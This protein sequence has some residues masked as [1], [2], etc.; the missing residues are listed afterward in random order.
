MCFP[1]SQ[2]QGG[3]DYKFDSRP[4]KTG[5]LESEISEKLSRGITNFIFGSTEAVRTPVEWGESIETGAFKT[6]TLGIPFGILRAGARTLVGLY[7]IVTC[8]APQKPIMYPL[9]GD[10][11]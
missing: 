8:Y 4:V 11:V 7:E 5:Q 9:E 3:Y 6:L 1:F 2:V 10:V